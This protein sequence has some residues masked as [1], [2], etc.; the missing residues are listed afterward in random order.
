MDIE[1]K[2]DILG[3]EEKSLEDTVKA[4]E[5]KASEKIVKVKLGFATRRSPGWRQGTAS[6]AGEQTT[7]SPRRGLR[8][9]PPR[10]R[11]V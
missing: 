7:P 10:T 8:C 3:A 2:E 9:V 1:I 6:S 4:I 11:Y 5:A